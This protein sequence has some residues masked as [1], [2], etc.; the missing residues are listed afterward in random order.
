[1]SGANKQSTLLPSFNETTYVSEEDSDIQYRE[2]WPD[3]DSNESDL[4][5]YE[6]ELNMISL[7]SPELPGL[8][9]NATKE[10]KALQ[11]Q[12][13]EFK[14]LLY[15]SIVSKPNIT[16]YKSSNTRALTAFLSIFLHSISYWMACLNKERE[17][18]PNLPEHTKKLH[19]LFET[20]TN[21]IQSI[22]TYQ[23]NDNHILLRTLLFHFSENP[24]SLNE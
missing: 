12:I 2:S 9:S 10:M 24:Y 16:K 14:K 19:T 15:S 4:D 11:S 8:E 3:I 7:A 1:M 18:E 6:E 22:S 21:E 5:E 23:T 13:L 20:I 17:M